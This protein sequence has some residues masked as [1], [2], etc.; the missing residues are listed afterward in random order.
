MITHLGIG[1]EQFTIIDT[2][3]KKQVRSD[4]YNYSFDKKTGRFA[5][6]GKTYEDDPSFSPIGPEILDIEISVNGCPNGAICKACYKNNTPGLA[7]NMSFDTFKSIIDKFKRT[8]L[9]QVA[10]GITG[11]QTNPDFIKMMKYCR[12]IGVIPNFT[13]SGIDL[14]DELAKEC[15]E[16]I[17]AVAVSVYESDKSVCYDTVK[18]FTDLGINQCNIHC[19]VSQESLNFIDEV[20]ED[21]K[22]DSR[23]AKLNAIVFLGVKPKGRAKGKFSSLTTEQYE[24]LIIR[25]FDK[26]IPFGFDSC[27]AP[28]FEA[29]IKGA[30]L[31]LNFGEKEKYL[32]LSESCESSVFSSYVNIIGE[33]FACSFCEREPIF[34]R[35]VSVLEHDNFLD[36]WYS[37]ETK[38]FRKKLL[39]SEVDGC[40]QCLAF[41]TINP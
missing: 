28:K 7:V 27:S 19:M 2:P 6:W 16:V 10:F 38:E 31:E 20:L 29:A 40:R 21:I 26:E 3:E 39:A 35:G 33:F 8:A 1:D 11:I 5:R 41:P 18:K 17:G 25:C 24:K 12:E 14:T 34:P 22:T 36:V 37:K 23:L 15:A 9:C 13:L 30:T 4:T 32:S